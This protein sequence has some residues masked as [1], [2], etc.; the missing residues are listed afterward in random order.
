MRIAS[1]ATRAIAGAALVLA[2]STAGPLAQA[3]IQDHPGQYDRAD[4]EA[5]SRLYSAQCAPC[6]GTNG[7]MVAGVDLRRG[8]FKTVISDDDLT[9]LLATGRP[10]SGMPAFASF[11][12][13]EVTGVIAFIRAGFD[14]GGTA[15]RIGD[16]ARGQTLFAGKGGC[17]A[18]HRIN[19]SGPRVAAD[20]SDIGTIRTPASLQRALLEPQRSLAPANRA[21]RA[22]TRDG[23]IVRGRRLNEDTY[24]L[25]I[26]D[27]EE[28]LVS[29]SKTDL[30]SFSFVAE[31]AM[32]PADRVMTPTEVSDVIAYLLSLKGVKP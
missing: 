13:Q 18:C 6:H 23:R 1:L 12:P 20:L 19:G 30:R 32:P 14:A 22:I 3:P 10:A 4:I 8:V 21:V 16:P 31:T 24:T 27:E 15:V 9:R 7:D 11:Q 17:T 25:Q 2:L 5:G 28:R 29:L 26:I